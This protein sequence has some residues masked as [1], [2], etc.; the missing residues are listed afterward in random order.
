MKNVILAYGVWIKDGR[1][2]LLERDVREYNLPW[3]TVW[4][5]PGGRVDWGE[6]PADAAV[7]E[8]QEETGLHASNPRFLGM[9]RD[10]DGS[11][12]RNILY[13][14]VDAKE[15]HVRLGDP[16]HRDWQMIS[17]DAAARVENLAFTTVAVLH[18]LR[19]WGIWDGEIR[20]RRDDGYVPD[21]F[22]P[23]KP[24]H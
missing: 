9:T 21:I 17:L 11:A 18:L 16:E 5:V 10:D 24:R 6:N 7:R 13:Y 22:L 2:F 15:G 1:I 3:P 4:E 8:F 14:L 20:S 12:R 23:H 19:I